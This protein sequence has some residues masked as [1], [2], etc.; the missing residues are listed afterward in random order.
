MSYKNYPMV[1]RVIFGRG[2]FNQL[3]DI[4]SPKRLNSTAPFIFLVD[5][6]FKGNPDLTP[7]GSRF[8]GPIS[9]FLKYKQG[10]QKIV[11]LAKYFI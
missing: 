7:L 8:K 1:S 2:S 11:S 9:A 3:G 6:V 5:D 10:C 4:I